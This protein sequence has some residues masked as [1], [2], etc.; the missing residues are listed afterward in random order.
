[1][2]KIGKG[3]LKL[4]SEVLGLLFT[5]LLSERTG[6]TW[7]IHLL[8]YLDFFLELL[9]MIAVLNVIAPKETQ[10][11]R[12]GWSVSL[13]YYQREL[14]FKQP[15]MVPRRVTKTESYRERPYLYRARTRAQGPIPY[16]DQSLNELEWLI[17]P[18]LLIGW[19]L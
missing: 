17:Q 3:V 7:I 1:M 6:V 14:V 16:A 9:L 13:I 12:L 15:N 4:P 2:S 11:G 8:K 10:E 18:E 19:G 5:G